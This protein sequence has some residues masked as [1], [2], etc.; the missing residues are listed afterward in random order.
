M[1]AIVASVKNLIIGAVYERFVVY[2][3]PTYPGRVHDKHIGDREGICFLHQ[4]ELDKD[5]GF[6]GFEPPNVT[7]Y[8]PKKKAPNVPQSVVDQILNRVINAVCVRIEHSIAGIK[9]SRSVKDI[10]RN[11]VLDADDVMTIACGLHNFRV[12]N[13]SNEMLE[14]PVGIFINTM[15]LEFQ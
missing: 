13:R 14:T 6:Q 2:L 5:K 12:R 10:F 15:A 8:Q 9:R 7:T 11:Y 1:K 3:S 4:I